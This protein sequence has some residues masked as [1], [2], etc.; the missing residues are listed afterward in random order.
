MSA[1]PDSSDAALRRALAGFAEEVG[2]QAVRE[3][4]RQLGE[5][6]QPGERFGDYRIRREIGRGGMG[7]VYEAEQISVPGRIVAVK[8]LP[9]VAGSST[10]R[11]RFAREVEV[12][13]QLDHPHIVP[14][15]SADLAAAVPFFAMKRVEGTSLRELLRAGELIDDCRRTATWIR[16]LAHAL[17]HAHE[18]GVVHR[19][20]KPGNVIIDQDD[21]AMLLDFGLARVLEEFSDLTLS[22]DAVGTLDYMAPEQLCPGDGC[23]V[24]PTDVAGRS[25]ARSTSAPRSPRVES[26]TARTDIYSLGVTLYECLTSRTPFRA[27]SRAQTLERI[28]RGDAPGVRALN[29]GVPRDLANICAMA[30]HRDPARRY[31]SAG[32]FAADLEAF[33]RFRPVVARPVGWLRR[34]AVVAR[35]HQLVT[36]AIVA[37][38]VVFLAAGAYW[39]WWVPTRERRA[40]HDQ[41]ETVLQQGARLE[42]C[43]A[44]EQQIAAKA[45]EIENRQQ[46]E[47]HPGHDPQLALLQVELRRLVVEQRRRMG[48]LETALE[49]CLALDSSHARTLA[50]FADLLALQLRRLLAGGGVVSRR[51]QIERQQARLERVDLERRH[52]AL[53]EPYGQ[54]AIRC[55][56]GPARVWLCPAIERS[57]GRLEYAAAGDGAASDLGTT[58]VERAIAEGNYALRAALAGC[59]D[60]IVPVLVRRRAVQSPA[61]RSLVL[62]PATRA[63][64]GVGFRQVHGGMSVVV[65]ARGDPFAQHEELRAVEGFAMTEREVRADDVRTWLGELP[66]FLPSSRHGPMLAGLSWAETTQLVHLLNLRER[67]QATGHYVS[68]P[69][70]EQW[71]WASQGADGRP[72]PWGWAHDWRFSQNSWSRD[73]AGTAAQPKDWPE[74]V[75]PFGIRDLAGSLRE[76]CLPA[77]PMRELGNR[78]FLLCGGSHWSFRAEDQR[79]WTNRSLLHGETTE[80]TGLRLVRRQ[81]PRLPDGPRALRLQALAPGPHAELPAGWRLFGITGPFFEDMTGR[82]QARIHDGGLV[83]DGFRGFFSPHLMAWHPIDRPAAPTAV[84]MSFRFDEACETSRPLEIRL[85]T[86]ADVE[87]HDQWVACQLRR[88]SVGLVVGGV[89]STTLARHALPEAALDATYHVTL[90]VSER[91]ATAT[92]STSASAPVV[93]RGDCQDAWPT[94][95]RYV[96]VRLPSYIGLRVTVLDLAVAER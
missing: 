27:S 64:I 56:R 58:P 66:P 21:R 30:M 8:V 80:D 17:Q 18:R 34:L 35:R 61:E 59:E 71:D 14:I 39:T 90:T 32:A 20:V 87:P 6:Q 67:E 15:L 52:A 48:E 29:P 23:A 19:D 26:I 47:D 16:D 93:V 49:T 68:L 94:A 45:A 82:G 3:T 75:S 74:D 63:E 78:H 42:R 9:G 24:S 55:E 33:L 40:R 50:C 72:Y 83:L 51:E 12:T 77:A 54:L 4:L 60:L 1:R 95:W 92:V 79:S 73:V 57:D 41:I 88:D 10:A 84:A 76:V 13:G 81:L 2:A 46:R 91:S 28:A 89:N 62:C 43:V 36:V 25:H 70:P 65:A 7:I 22:L 37:A 69:S 38:T 86:R 96:G 11:R 5:A 31:P 44:L 85:G 53:L